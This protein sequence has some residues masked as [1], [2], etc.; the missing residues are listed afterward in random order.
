MKKSSCDMGKI[1][2]SPE[3]FRTA[4]EMRKMGYFYSVKFFGDERFI[5]FKDSMNVGSV[6]RDFPDSKMEWCGEI[7]NIV[8]DEKR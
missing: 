4:R 8:L 2:T 7:D 1:Q 5:H 3:E 6:L